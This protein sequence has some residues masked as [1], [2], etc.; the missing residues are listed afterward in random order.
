MRNV[1]ALSS[2][3]VLAWVSLVVVSYGYSVVAS[4]NCA[5]R[6][7]K[8]GLIVE[9]TNERATKNLP[10]MATQLR[11]HDLDLFFSGLF[12]RSPAP[13]PCLQTLPRG[14]SFRLP[15]FADVCE[16]FSVGFFFLCNIMQRQEAGNLVLE[17]RLDLRQLPRTAPCVPRRP[18]AP[19][20]FAVVPHALTKIGHEPQVH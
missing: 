6:K 14:Q 2:T 16:G 13:Q 9:Y 8:P 1:S 17:P 12:R 4:R 10:Q 7:L 18:T 19:D 3:W 11:G 5:L 20:R 15:G